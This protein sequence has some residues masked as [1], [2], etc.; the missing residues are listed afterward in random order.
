[1][2]SDCSRYYL[3]DSA[4]S[5]RS[6]RKSYWCP[7]PLK[8]WQTF[9]D[10]LVPGLPVTDIAPGTS[11]AETAEMLRPVLF[12]GRPIPPTRLEGVLELWL[13]ATYTRRLK[14]SHLWV[15]LVQ[16]SVALAA[17]LQGAR[18]RDGD[19]WVRLQDDD[20]IAK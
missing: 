15:W 6:M 13:S 7:V 1:M 12:G 11:W 17:H 18:V 4:D 20:A 10:E 8:R 19:R 5:V 9:D 3:Y 2:S 16:D 14:G